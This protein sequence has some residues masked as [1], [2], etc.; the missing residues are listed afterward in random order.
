M[1]IV[2]FQLVFSKWM[3]VSIAIALA[4]IFWIIF[5]VFDQLLFFSPIVTFYLPEEAT[6]D[7]ILSNIAAALIG[8]VV[9]MN[10][11]VLKHSKILKKKVGFASLFS[12]STLGVVSSTCAS[13]SSLIGLLLVSTFG[14]VGITASAFLSNYQIP[15]RIL[16]ILLLVWA[17]YSI[18]NKLKK[19]CTI[20]NKQKD[21]II[22]NIK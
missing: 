10:T 1:L 8:V 19:S 18:S 5:N 7:F 3:Y 9:S 15:L 13:C 20:S 11:Y 22:K 21:D 4:G 2:S 14:G 12:G 16:L 17:L 6:V